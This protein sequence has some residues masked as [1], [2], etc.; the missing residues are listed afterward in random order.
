[1]LVVPDILKLVTDVIAPP[2]EELPVIVKAID[3]PLIVVELVIVEPVKVRVPVPEMVTA[4]EYVCIPEVVTSAPRS[5]VVD[6]VN[7]EALVIAAFRSRAPVIAIAPRAFVAP[8]VSADE[9]P[10]TK[11][12]VPKA[13]VRFLGV[14]PSLFNVPLNVTLPLDVVVNVVSAVNVVAPA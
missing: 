3:P 5:E 13:A 1:M 7:D 12:P 14:A 6:T 11:V 2:I 4:P 10:I 8:T 9:S